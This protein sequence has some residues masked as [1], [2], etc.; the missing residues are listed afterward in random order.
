MKASP[1]PSTIFEDSGERFQ[2]AVAL[3]NRQEWY[4]AHDLFEE[5]W[6][7]A[8]GEERELL[9][10]IIQIAVAEHHWLNGNK[11]GSLLLMAEGLNHLQATADQELALDLASLIAVVQQRLARLQAGESLL[12]LPWPVLGQLEAAQD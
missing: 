11:R 7:E 6:H 12:D 8:M 3:F 2:A 4:D 1:Q 10:G 9:Q 5:L